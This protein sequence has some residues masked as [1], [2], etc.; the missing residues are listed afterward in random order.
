[1][2]ILQL[3]R[4]QP[5][6]VIL[7]TGAEKAATATGGPY[8]HAALAIGKLFKIEA[9]LGVG[10]VCRPFELSAFYRGD[11]RI[12]GVPVTGDMVVKR[13]NGG[14]NVGE[15]QGRALLEA[16]RDYHIANA[17]DLPDLSPEV[18]GAL[19]EKLR[20]RRSLP[21][22]DKRICSEVIAHILSLGDKRVSPNGLA[23]APEL[24][25]VDD[26]IVELDDDWVPDPTDTGAADLLAEKVRGI[27]PR[28]E[29][30]AMEAA[31]EAVASVKQGDVSID[32]VTDKLAKLL[33]EELHRSVGRMLDITKLE[34]TILHN[35]I[36]PV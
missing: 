28:L 31:I 6:D 1:M 23:N 27:E 13:R 26:A 21:N 16:G 3:D 19:T 22:S 36:T 25:T 12:V 17:L 15:V 34:Q 29:K 9:D 32:E 24:D 14:V 33:D 11:R 5:G 8:G 30:R 20:G 2:R 4:L 7:E 35:E 10:V 18:R